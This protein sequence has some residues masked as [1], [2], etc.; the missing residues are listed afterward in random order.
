MRN[1]L[2]EMTNRLTAHPTYA[3]LAA[4]CATGYA[5]TLV[6]DGDAAILGAALELDGHRVFYRKP[7]PVTTDWGPVPKRGQHAH[8]LA[9]RFGL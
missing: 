4:A 2:D 6:D 7:T 9:K 8:G 3:S 5:P 1:Q